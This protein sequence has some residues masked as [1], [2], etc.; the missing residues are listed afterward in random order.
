[1]MS[2]AITIADVYPQDQVCI[3]EVGLRDGLQ[4]VK[5]FPSTAAKERWIAID[6]DAGIRHF[7]VGSYL[8]AQ[9][10]PQ[11][12]DVDELLGKV[13]TLSGA[14]SSVLA[15]NKRGAIRALEGEAHEI[16]CVVSASEEHNMRNARRSRADGLREIAEVVALRNAGPRKPL[17][18]VGIA[19]GFGC[20]IAGKDAVPMQ[21]VV[22]IADACAQSGVDLIGVAD[23]VGYGGPTQ[24][25]LLIR[26]LRK[27]L[28]D[29]PIAMHFHDTRGMGISNAAAA[30]DEGVRILDASLA[31][32]GGCPFAPKATGNIVLEDV[33]FLA[34]TMGFQTGIDIDALMP[35]REI[36]K[37]EM[38]QET[39]YGQMARAGLP[40]VAPGAPIAA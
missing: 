21:E 31:G 18:A 29:F 5:S 38:P 4:L 34:S 2:Q 32:L 1:M 28:G 30:L 24:V 15:L 13:A 39:L 11:F 17:V 26:E 22:R 27:A 10:F 23:T 37:K 33:A 20:S 12:V 9:S 25:R 3:R 14:F 35:A 40:L 8:P 36:L 19:M 6:H 7:E 16:T